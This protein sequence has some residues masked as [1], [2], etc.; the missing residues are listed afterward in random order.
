MGITL[1]AMRASFP[2][3]NLLFLLDDPAL[4]TDRIAKDIQSGFYV[5]REVYHPSIYKFLDS[6]GTIEFS[7]PISGT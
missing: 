5:Y 2:R 3:G 6:K 7:N 4:D 1:A